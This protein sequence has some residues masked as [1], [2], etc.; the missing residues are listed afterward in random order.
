MG[1]KNLS[2][3]LRDWVEA[4]RRHARAEDDNRSPGGV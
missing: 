1:E 4:R 3:S 2:Q